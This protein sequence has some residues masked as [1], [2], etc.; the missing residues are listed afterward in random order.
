MIAHM[1]AYFAPLRVRFSNEYWNHM[2]TTQTTLQYIAEEGIV[3]AYPISGRNTDRV[4]TDEATLEE[5]R[6]RED[7]DSDGSGDGTYG[8]WGLFPPQETKKQKGDRNT[9]NR[10]SHNQLIHTHRSFCIIEY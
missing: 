8:N 2:R 1:V 7:V 9:M 5:E 4:W 6:E 10:E 3:F